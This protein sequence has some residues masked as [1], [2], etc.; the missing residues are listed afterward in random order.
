MT[1]VLASLSLF[2]LGI[3]GPG[4]A[5]G[6]VSGAP[7]LGAGAPS[8]RR[9]TG[10][11]RGIGGAGAMAPCAL[12]APEWARSRRERARWRSVHGLP[13][14]A[15][16]LRRR[17]ARPEWGPDLPAS[18]AARL[19]RQA[20]PGGI[21]AERL[22]RLSASAQAGREAAFRATGGT[23]SST[24]NPHP[25]SERPEHQR[26]LPR[27]AALQ[28]APRLGPPTASEQRRRAHAHA[29]QA[30][31]EGDRPGHAATPIS[32][33]RSSDVQTTLQRY[34]KTPEPPRPIRGPRKLGT[35]ASARPACRPENWR[36]MSFGSLAW[37]FVLAGGAI[38]QS[39][40]SRVVPY[41]VQVDKFGAVQ[42]VGPADPELYPDRCRDRL[43]SG[44]LHHHVRSLSIDPV[45]VAQTGM[46]YDYT[47]DHGGVSQPVRPAPT[48][49]SSRS[50]S[51]L[52]RRRSPASCASRTIRFK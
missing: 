10:R 46:A 14:G 5:T 34:G 8:G 32:T 2:G 7:Q 51:A 9:G 3:F 44:R 21:H 48:I 22:V 4:I 26:C 1:L 11:R 13:D 12:A 39:V 47:T 40:Q 15:G 6:L 43:V 28:R 30:I 52:S 18:P 19:P 25:P 38:W 36:L 23:R 20:G 27:P 41:V 24:A 45:V 42:A 33:K 29:A 16:H 50:A 49:P 35:T 37:L 17:A 31:K